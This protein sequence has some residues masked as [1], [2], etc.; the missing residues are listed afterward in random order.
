M[1]VKETLIGMYQNSQVYVK[2]IEAS[3]IDLEQFILLLGIK[4]QENILKLI[5]FSF[6]NDDFYIFWEYCE[7]GNIE[8]Y[9]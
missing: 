8:E 9:F 1:Y 5:G 4:E 6:K 3:L 7:C 2:K